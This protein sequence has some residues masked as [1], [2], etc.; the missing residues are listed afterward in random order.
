MRTSDVAAGYARALF[1][2]ATLAD[3]VDET[4]ASLEALALAVRGHIDLRSALTDATVPAETKRGV[5]REIF[6]ES[7][8]PEAL[9]IVTTMVERGLTDELGE[10]ARIFGEVAEAERGVVV[11]RVTTAVALDDAMRASLSDKLAASLGRPVSLR[12]SVDASLVGG[13][14]IK[15]AGRVLDG[16]LASQLVDVRRALTTA[17][18]GE[19]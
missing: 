1:E 6:G 14:I 4:D 13:I 10:L 8:T 9:A 11:A 19:A 15:V 18:G 2:L 12:E 17:Q 3:S 16:S 5:L 7:V